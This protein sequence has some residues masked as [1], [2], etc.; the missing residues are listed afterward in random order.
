MRLVWG[1]AMTDLIHLL[2][3]LPD[4]LRALAAWLDDLLDGAFAAL[5][6]D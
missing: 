3:R 1:P 5:V 6:N 2:G 4:A